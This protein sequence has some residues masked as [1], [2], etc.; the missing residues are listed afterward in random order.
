MAYLING[1]NGKEVNYC[2]QL[3]QFYKHIVT[4]QINTWIILNN[5]DKHKGK[6]IGYTATN[7]HGI[8]DNCINK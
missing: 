1:T 2:P 7:Y 4:E 8:A 5:W 3:N 6:M